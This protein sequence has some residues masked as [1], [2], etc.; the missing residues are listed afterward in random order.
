MDIVKKWR[1][2]MSD[3]TMQYILSH[4]L[5]ISKL[6]AQLL[7]N[8]GIYSAT[9]ARE[10]L[11]VSLDRLHSPLMMKDMEKGV[12]LAARALKENKRILVYGDYDVDGVTGT[13][14][15]VDVLRRL[16]GN[17]EYYIPHRLEE[18]Y[19]LNSPALKRA[20][21]KGINL[22]ITVDC[23]ISNVAEVTEANSSGGPD[24]IITDHHEPPLDIPAA[25]AVINPKRRDCT[26]PFR[27]LAGVGVAFKFAAALVEEWDGPFDPLD[28]LDLVCLGTVADI[29]PLSGENRILVKFGLEKLSRPQRPGLQAL[30]QAAGLKTDSPGTREVGYILAPRINAAGRLGDAGIAVDLLMSQEPEPAMYL[31]AALGKNNQTRQELETVALGE[32]LGMLD[33]APDLAADKV[34]VLSSPNW[35]S[36]VIGIVA[37]RL[38]KRYNKPALLIAGQGDLGKGSARSVRGFNLVAALKNCSHCLVEYGGHSMAAGFSI[39]LQEVE[40]LRREINRYASETMENTDSFSSLDL[41]ALISLEDVT[42]K[43]VEEIERLEPFGEGNPRPLFGLSGAKLINCRSVGKN[44]AHLKLLLGENSLNMDGIGFNLGRHA[45][46]L[47]A[48]REINVAVIPTVN[49]W[50]GRQHLQVRVKD[51]HG[52]TDNDHLSR[53]C[54]EWESCFQRADDFIFIPDSI[55]ARLQNYLVLNRHSVPAAMQALRVCNLVDPD[56]SNNF[57]GGVIP[58]CPAPAGHGIENYLACLEPAAKPVLL[59][60]DCASQTLQLARF[61]EC[62]NNRFSGRVTFVNG[63]MPEDQIKGELHKVVNGTFKLL[64][65]TYS[66]LPEDLYRRTQFDRILLGRPP[67]IAEDW[68]TLAA[69]NVDAAAPEV[70]ALFSAPDWER[71]L[72]HIEELAPDRELLASFY[73]ILRRRAAGAQETCSTREALE[74]LRLAG[75]EM[76]SCL[77][78]VVAAAVFQELDLL[79]YQ[80]EEGILRYKLLPVGAQR[81]DLNES[82]TYVWTRTIKSEW[83]NWI[84]YNFRAAGM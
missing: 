51:L 5:G 63:F 48:G 11:D 62:H 9:F 3:P 56:N 82:G 44:E 24:I 47:A 13:A 23:G 69:R 1:V 77:P 4:K 20:G 73:A 27:E 80:W 19:G 75:R 70:E 55:V 18:G 17:V 10:F 64:V 30:F 26:Y 66:C 32:A 8:R 74:H 39:D 45:G 43:L 83:V 14:L 29:V 67:A 22:V 57:S 59:L 15:L 78:L 12:A 42:Y 52:V 41:D 31:A 79:Q 16:G 40:H 2:K 65:A 36:G 61:A 33:G 54:T 49:Q 38:V 53:R 58:G 50:Q 34:I 6:L 28:Y 25:A 81:R 21:E 60:V 72:A 84:K 7:I 68:L 71:S 35:H 76:S 46:Q 37:S